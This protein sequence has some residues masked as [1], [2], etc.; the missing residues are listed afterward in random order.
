V[1]RN[2]HPKVVAKASALQL[3]HFA[4]MQKQLRGGKDGGPTGTVPNVTAPA[5]P[6]NREMSFA[7]AQNVPKYATLFSFP[8]LARK[9]GQLRLLSSL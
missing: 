9:R 3:P 6:A 4:L 7:P 8:F 2:L 1:L 5:F